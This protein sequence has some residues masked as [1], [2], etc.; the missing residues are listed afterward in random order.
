MPTD[1]TDVLPP[2]DD[3]TEEADEFDAREAEEVE[4][5]FWTH[6]ETPFDDDFPW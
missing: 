4:R 1:D 6:V 3:A 5:F 2:I